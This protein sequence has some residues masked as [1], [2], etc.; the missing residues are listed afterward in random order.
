MKSP[1][2]E[3]PS[4]AQ[5]TKE[6]RAK[7]QVEFTYNPLDDSEELMQVVRTLGGTGCSVHGLAGKLGQS[8][9][10]GA[11]RMK[12]YSA[13][14]F[15]LA[16]LARDRIELTDLGLRIIDPKHVKAARV[17]AFLRVP[18]FRL[19]FEQLHGQQMPPPAA[20]ERMMVQAGVPPKQ[21]DRARQVFMRSAKAAGFFDIHPERLIKPELGEGAPSGSEGSKEAPAKPAAVSD[22]MDR[23]PARFRPMHG[24]GGNE[25][26]PPGVQRLEVPIPG[27]P[28]VV[29][30]VPEAIDGEDWNMVYAMLNIYV[31]RWK[32]FTPTAA[33]KEPDQ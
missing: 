29:I 31:K 26:P 16:S 27:K 7:S 8:P 28:S 3:A 24:G 13:R 6:E 15:G 33:T 22:P 21:K 10:G 9:G 20:V 17:E 18:L 30:F 19:M 23:V 1:A 5:A 11:F 14:S 4:A 2:D 25:P 12:L 32:G